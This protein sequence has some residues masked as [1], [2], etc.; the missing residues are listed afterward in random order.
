MVFKAPVSG[1][2]SLLL[3]QSKQFLSGFIHLA[4]NF[5]ILVFLQ[6]A[7]MALVIHVALGCTMS[8]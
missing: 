2:M 8:Q 1:Q 4:C 7:S 6:L 5:F 3:T